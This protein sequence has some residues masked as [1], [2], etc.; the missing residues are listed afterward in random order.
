MVK[1]FSSYKCLS[2]SSTIRWIAA[3]LTVLLLLLRLLYV[4]WH[5]PVHQCILL[6]H[7]LLLLLLL[8]LHCCQLTLL[9]YKVGVDSLHTATSTGTRLSTKSYWLLAVSGKLATTGPS[10]STTGSHLIESTATTAHQRYIDWEFWTIIHMT[11]KKNVRKTY[12]WST[13]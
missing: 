9:L 2:S 7:L 12:I 6:Y 8:S 4:A 13:A 5:L 10:H 11:A 1:F 3:E